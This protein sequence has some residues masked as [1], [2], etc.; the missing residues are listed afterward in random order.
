MIDN[1]FDAPPPEDPLPTDANHP[2]QTGD[3]NQTF[4]NQEKISQVSTTVE[5]VNQKEPTKDKKHHNIIDMYWFV[6]QKLF[7]KQQMNEGEAGFLAVGYNAD[8]ANLRVG[9]YKIDGS[10]F[11]RASMI[12]DKMEF[13]TTINLFSETCFNI[14]DCLRT[15]KDINVSNY[16]RIIGAD[17]KWQPNQ[18]RI[19]GNT[20]QIIIHTIN[21]EGNKCSYTLLDWQITA[22][23]SA[24]RYMTEGQSWNKYLDMR[25]G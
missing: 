25:K 2:N 6:N 12:K 24:L 4:I 20:N 9:F 22:F 10:S 3:G 8:F 16:E 7:L 1:P 13:I 19:V 21:P 15:G 17:N 23:A 5:H 18:T 11:T 14:L